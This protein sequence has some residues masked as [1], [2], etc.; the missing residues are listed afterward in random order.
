MVVSFGDI[1][2]GHHGNGPHYI[3]HVLCSPDG[4]RDSEGV[5]ILQSHFSVSPV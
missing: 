2:S 3:V 5:V 4:S 1:S